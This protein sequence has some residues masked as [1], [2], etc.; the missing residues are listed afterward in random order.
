MQIQRRQSLIQPKLQGE[1]F[2]RGASHSQ[3]RDVCLVLLDNQVRHLE[4]SSPLKFPE[5]QLRTGDYRFR[6]TQVPSKG[7]RNGGRIFCGEI[8]YGVNP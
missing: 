4:L 1:R 8:G 2:A 6:F 5:S 3:P 7:A